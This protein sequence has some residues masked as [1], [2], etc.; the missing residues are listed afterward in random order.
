MVIIPGRDLS[1]P[2]LIARFNHKTAEEVTADAHSKEDNQTQV[3][4]TSATEPVPHKV[5]A[6]DDTAATKS[7][8]AAHK[9]AAHAKDVPTHVNETPADAPSHGRA[10]SRTSEA[11]KTSGTDASTVTAAAPS[12]DAPAET[13]STSAPRRSANKQQ[14]STDADVAHTH[15][16]DHTPS[17]SSER[18]AVKLSLPSEPEGR[19]VAAATTTTTTK[20]ADAVTPVS[21]TTATTSHASKSA[22]QHTGSKLH[23]HVNTAVLAPAS[24]PAAKTTT[25]RAKSSERATTKTK[26]TDT[27]T[28]SS[29]TT[30]TTVDVTTSTTTAARSRAKS[31]E[32]PQSEISKDIASRPKPTVQ[33]DDA[34]VQPTKTK[35]ADTA[36]SKTT[37]A[38]SKTAPKEV[39]KATTH[40]EPVETIKE[41]KNPRGRPRLNASVPQVPVPAAKATPVAKVPENAAAAEVVSAP[42]SS[43]R[44]A[45]KHVDYSLLD[46]IGR[47]DENVTAN[48]NKPSKA[49]KP[50]DAS[51][52]L[53]ETTTVNTGKRKEVTKTIAADV[54]MIEEVCFALNWC[55]SL[56]YDRSTMY[57]RVFM[58]WRALSR[59]GS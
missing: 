56:R 16:P 9:T 3:K 18:I 28:T 55:S 20:T 43:Q 42:K 21:K 8:H 40:S 49:S 59:T 15:V 36:T 47:A 7:P 53:Q 44:L 24:E 41:V 12:K 50:R 11:K 37:D 57:C 26:T 25:P 34:P 19:P 22:A 13:T 35:T 51:A 58:R 38:S 31:Q 6:S 17:R 27:D 39:T 5:P 48:A 32:R 30:A 33:P 45:T 14:A 46:D 1:Y 2:D 29:A 52:N 10:S 4:K 23:E 54:G